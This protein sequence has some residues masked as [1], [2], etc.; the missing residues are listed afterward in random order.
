MKAFRV[1]HVLSLVAYLAAVAHAFV[2]G[3]DSALPAVQIMYAG[4]FLV[5]VF[6]TVY[7]LVV[8]GKTP[9]VTQES[10]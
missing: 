7:W 1:I 2:S 10:I 8:R 9:S 5:V 3:T 4:T 6:L